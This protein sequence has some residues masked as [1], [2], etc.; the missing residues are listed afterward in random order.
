[1]NEIHAH[2]P[3]EMITKSDP[4]N[5]P[6]VIAD[7]STSNQPPAPEAAHPLGP[8]LPLFRPEYPVTPAVP[9]RP[10]QPGKQASPRTRAAIVSK[11]HH[12]QTFARIGRDLHPSA[13][14]RPRTDRE[15]AQNPKDQG[16]EPSRE[17]MARPEI[18]QSRAKKGKP[19][20]L[21]EEEKDRL[22]AVSR[23]SCEAK[24]MSLADLRTEAGLEGVPLRMCFKALKERGIG[25]VAPRYEGSEGTAVEEG[26]VKVEVKED[27][28]E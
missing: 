5:W 3:L 20:G 12:G 28:E 2:H 21:T 13:S 14:A 18:L 22:V 26:G 6:A 15:T 11:H 8:Q 27:P 17:N 19:R 10:R 9:A 23:T 24:M 16:L 7:S 4:S 1:M 25:P